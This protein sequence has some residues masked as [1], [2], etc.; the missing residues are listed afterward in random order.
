VSAVATSS[1]E[2]SP[3]ERV[4]TNVR[5]WRLHLSLVLGHLQGAALFEQFVEDIFPVSYMA[6]K[7][8][9]FSSSTFGGH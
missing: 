4:V 6:T 2:A 3:F 7:G 5:R 8:S 1:P 9:L